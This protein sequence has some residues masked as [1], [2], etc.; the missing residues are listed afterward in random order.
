MRGSF[1]IHITFTYTTFLRLSI[2]N[3]QTKSE[4]NNHIA[5]D[6]GTVAI[7]STDVTVNLLPLPIFIRHLISSNGE[8]TQ[9]P[10]ISYPNP[11][12][13]L[14]AASGAEPA[15]SNIS[16]IFVDFSAHLMR[17]DL[18]AISKWIKNGGVKQCWISGHVCGYSFQRHYYCLHAAAAVAVA[19]PTTLRPNPSRYLR[20]IHVSVTR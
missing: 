8:S 18:I 14:V 9:L 5:A 2:P 15:Q 4:P 12:L 6:T 16:K 10:S 20:T 17:I 1:F 13:T 3:K 7:S 19:A 11:E